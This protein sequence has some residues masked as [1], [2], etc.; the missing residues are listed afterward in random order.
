MAALIGYINLL[1][2][3][4][5]PAPSKREPVFEQRVILSSQI[6]CIIDDSIESAKLLPLVTQPELPEAVTHNNK[7]LPISGNIR[8]SPPFMDVIISRNSLC[9]KAKHALKLFILFCQLK[10]DLLDFFSDTN[11]STFKY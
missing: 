10:S 7:A 4:I 5:Q 2:V 11:F 3:L 6:V 9:N 1:L 8:L